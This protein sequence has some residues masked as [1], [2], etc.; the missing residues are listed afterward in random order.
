LAPLVMKLLEFS[1]RHCPLLIIDRSLEICG[2]GTLL[3]WFGSGLG[4]SLVRGARACGGLGVVRVNTSSHGGD[5]REESLPRSFA[6]KEWRTD[7]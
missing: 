6:K 5:P 7:G 4:S 1:Q 3:L 2:F